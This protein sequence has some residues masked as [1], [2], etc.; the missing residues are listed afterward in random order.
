MSASFNSA[1]T[2]ALRF[3]RNLDIDAVTVWVGVMAFLIFASGA[4]L[5]AA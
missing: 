5:A 1:A 2:G 4:A 3:R